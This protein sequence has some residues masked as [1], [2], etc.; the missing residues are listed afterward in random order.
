M[1]PKIIAKEPLTPALIK[2]IHFELTQR[3]YDTIRWEKGERP[4]TFK[5]NDSCIADGQGALPSEVPDEISEL[6]EEMLDIPDRGDNI[7][8]A[9][10]YLHCKFENIHPF[11]DGNGRVGRTL[12][13]YMLTTHNYPPL[14]VKNESK[15]KYYDALS[16]YDKTGEVDQFVSYMKRSLEETWSLESVKKKMLKQIIGENIL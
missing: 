13:N 16:Y 14:I 3:T 1:L 8:K 6:C 5:V 15:D 2:N 4:G 9:A 12:M 7:L 11:A 10:A